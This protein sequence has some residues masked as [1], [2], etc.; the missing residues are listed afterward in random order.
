MIEDE[1]INMMDGDVTTKFIDGVPTINFSERV[2]T[3]V[4]QSMRYGPSQKIRLAKTRANL[5]EDI[6]ME[7]PLNNATM[8]IP[9]KSEKYGPQML[10]ERRNC[11]ANHKGYGNRNGNETSNQDNK[12][13]RDQDLCLLLRRM[14]IRLI[15]IIMGDF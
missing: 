15:M 3:L 9:D 12:N 13:R 14:M 8:V 2:H 6:V 5:E 11:R 1:D 4:E 7:Q 10:V